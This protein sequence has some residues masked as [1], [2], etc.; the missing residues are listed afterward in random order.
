MSDAQELD[1]RESL[2][3]ESADTDRLLEMAEQAISESRARRGAAPKTKDEEQKPLRVGESLKAWY[4]NF[5]AEQ[6]DPD[7]GRIA[8]TSL[9]DLDIKTKL[10][11]GEMTIIAGRPGMGKSVLAVQVAMACARRGD[12]VALFSLEMS[13]EQLVSR[14]IS[15]EARVNLRHPVGPSQFSKIAEACNTLNQWPLW[16]DDRAGINLRQMRAALIQI[17]KPKLIVVDYIGLMAEDKSASRHD[18]AVGDNA[19]GIRALAK[20]FGAHSLALCQLN[21]KVEERKPPRPQLS[22]LR[23]S[24]NLEEHADNVWMIYREGYYDHNADDTT[25]EIQIEKQRQGSR[26]VV[27]VGWQGKF[28]TFVNLVREHHDWQRAASGEEDES[29]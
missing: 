29:A 12:N 8:V 2:D 16:I 23:D 18:I 13:R 3:S 24:G 11:A 10:R 7:A 28:Q 9:G 1:W 17:P 26:G 20:D 21:R 19:K 15:S 22:D 5:E 25:A 4:M 14:M 6:K 27:K